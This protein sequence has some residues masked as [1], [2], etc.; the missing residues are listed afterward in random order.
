MASLENSNQNLILTHAVLTGLTPLI[1]IP[2][3]DDLAKSYFQ[4]RMVRKLSAVYNQ[5]ISDK[6]IKNLI[7]DRGGCLSGCLGMVLLFPFKLIFRKLFFFL[8]WKRAIDTV[9]LTYYQGYLIEY[10]LQQRYCAP[11]GPHTANQVRDAIDRV[12]R[13]TGTGPIERAVRGTF[14]QSKEVLKGAAELL[15]RSLQ[16]TPGKPDEN[17]VAQAAEAVEEEEENRIKG[18][19]SRLQEAI[20]DVPPGHF[21]RMRARLAELLGN[22]GR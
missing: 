19:T 15:Q 21:Q 9:S 2:I 1:P 10:A 20:K 3:L 6:D 5:N 7:D 17:R 12:C 13:E 11:A 22:P 14:S 18:V 16:R 4:R 8:E